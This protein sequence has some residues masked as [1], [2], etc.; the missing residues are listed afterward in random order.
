MCQA[1]VLGGWSPAQF[2][3]FP[4]RISKDVPIWDF[5]A[6]TVTYN[7]HPIVANTDINNRLMTLMPQSENE[8]Q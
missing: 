4:E 3:D 5:W 8:G 6:D 2:D 7:K 1:P